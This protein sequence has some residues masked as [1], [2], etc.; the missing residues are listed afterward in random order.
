MAA[1]SSL[2]S[3]LQLEAPVDSTVLSEWCPVAL[4]VVQLA[5]QSGDTEMCFMDLCKAKSLD[6]APSHKVMYVFI[7]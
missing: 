4:W 5:L 1:G 6:S 3:A 7:F 2:A